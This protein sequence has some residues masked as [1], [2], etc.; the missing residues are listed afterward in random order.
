MEEI[1]QIIHSIQ[2]QWAEAISI[3]PFQ[4]SLSMQFPRHYF[5]FHPQLTTAIWVNYEC[6]SKHVP[7]HHTEN[8]T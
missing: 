7:N 3:Y 1:H 8:Q 5:Y 4:L 2:A 6:K